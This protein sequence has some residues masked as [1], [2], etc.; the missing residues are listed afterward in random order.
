MRK[1]LQ[2]GAQSAPTKV[3]QAIS[4]ELMTIR[5]GAADHREAVRHPARRWTMRQT[6]G[7]LGSWDKGR[8]AAG[9]FIKDV[10]APT[11]DLTLVDQKVEAAPEQPWCSATS[12][13]IQEQQQK[14]I[15][16]QTRGMVR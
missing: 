8:H 2:R 13:P 9:N 15:D 11:R 3:Q 7:D 12:R 10:P 4:A 6:S 16:L 5:F 1:I 14:L